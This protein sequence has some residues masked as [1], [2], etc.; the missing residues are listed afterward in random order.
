MN[1][2]EVKIRAAL[3]EL[4][5]ETVDADGVWLKPSQCYRIGTNPYHILFNTN[6][7][8]Q[9]RNKIELILKTYS[10]V[11]SRQFE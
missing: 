6:C 3:E 10:G 2:N 4:E 1:A 11:E 5:K 7:P 9:L 8:D